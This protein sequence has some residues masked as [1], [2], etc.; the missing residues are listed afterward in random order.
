LIKR[1]PDQQITLFDAI[2]AVLALQA[3]LNPSMM[4]SPAIAQLGC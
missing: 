4:Q 3:K 2:T 1:F